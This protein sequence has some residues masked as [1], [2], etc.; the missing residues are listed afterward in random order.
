MAD[1][2]SENPNLVRDGRVEAQ[3]KG[4]GE[5]GDSLLG[6]IERGSVIVG[7]LR[8]Y[9]ITEADGDVFGVAWGQQIT[10]LWSEILGDASGK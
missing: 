8:R 3:R 4:C 9:H 1:L 10:V 5:Q 2:D 7:V 6:E